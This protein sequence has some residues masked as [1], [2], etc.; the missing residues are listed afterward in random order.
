VRFASFLISP[1]GRLRGARP[2]H[3]PLGRD[4]Q[5]GGECRMGQAAAELPLVPPRYSC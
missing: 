4:D 2:G 3:P 5:P 1:V